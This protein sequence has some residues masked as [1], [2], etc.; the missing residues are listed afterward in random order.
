MEAAG[1][2]PPLACRGR[3][4][5]GQGPSSEGGFKFLPFKNEFP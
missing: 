1:V 3:A 2:V 4:L 5:P